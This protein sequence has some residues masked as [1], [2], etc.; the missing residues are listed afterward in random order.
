[1]YKY[2]QVLMLSSAATFIYSAPY[3]RQQFK[4]PLME[5]FQLTEMQLGNLSSTYGIACMLCYLPGGWLADRVSPRRLV[6]TSLLAGA[7]TFAWMAMVPG[8]S[9]LLVIYASW[10]VIGIL[11]LWSAMLRQVR[12]IGDDGEQGRL[13]GLLEGSRGLFEAALFT[14]ASLLFSWFTVQ[15]AG[16]SAVFGLYALLSG[17]LGLWM[18]VGSKDAG[19]DG[20]ESAAIKISDVLIIVREPTV[21][22]MC[23][24]LTAVFHLFWA[25][26]EFPSFGE[27]AGFEMT[28]AATLAMGTLRVWMRPV[29]GV[30][31]GI[32]GD[33][34]AN[35]R[36]VLW[37]LAVGTAICVFL[38]TMS[39]SP[40]STWILWAL[41]VPF[42]SLVYAVRGLIW[43]VLQDCPIP[44][45]LTG[46]AIGFIS[47]MGYSS[48]IYIPQVSSYLL[49]TYAD[50]AGYQ[51]FFA[52]IA[53]ASVIGFGATWW[54][55]RLGAADVPLAYE[56]ESHVGAP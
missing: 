51:L 28:V 49:S 40:G 23:V 30:L 32:V 38:A 7:V 9:S 27:R 39:T 19:A 33:R 50:Q 10:G 21:W 55:M 6:I 43:A 52:Y 31:G 17:G 41:V 5:A 4:S 11:V 35:A 26:I 42:G 22:L 12:V 29:G 53:V 3:L 15:A 20:A 13:F 24:M 46:T 45:Y 14:L 25:I 44:R 47:I 37:L 54:L 36:A 1:L 56:A 8:Y 2:A 34:I 16:I 48:D 18:L